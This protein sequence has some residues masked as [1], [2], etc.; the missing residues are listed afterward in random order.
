MSAQIGVPIYFLKT[1]KLV[2]GEGSRDSGACWMSAIAYRFNSGENWTDQ[3]DCVCPTI[4]RMCISVNDQLPSDDSRSRVIGPYLFEPVGTA[5]NDPQ[6][7]EARRWH[8]V[9]AAVRRFAPAAMDFAKLPEWAAKLRALPRV[10]PLNYREAQALCREARASASA[11]AVAASAAA[12]AA[13]ADA[14]ADAASADAAAAAVAA[15]YAAAYAADAAAVAVADAYA[16][17]R[18]KFH[19]EVTVPVILEL[20]AIG[21]KRPVEEVRCV[22]E[23]CTK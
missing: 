10:T 16:A 19:A 1:I 21:D 9:D 7:I 5:T 6:V 11:A 15:A 20:C 23:L 3:P 13:D 17:A 8:L 12:Y 22:R 18:E 4:R 2:R 14:A